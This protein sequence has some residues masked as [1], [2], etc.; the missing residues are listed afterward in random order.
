MLDT[1]GNEIR[2]ARVDSGSTHRTAGE[3]FTL[4]TDDRM[5]NARDVSVS[6][7]GLADE[8]HEGSKILLDDGVIELRV[9]HIEN[10]YRGCFPLLA[11]LDIILS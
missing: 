8:L 11:P 10:P 9:R 6:Y 3:A 7:T 1:K 2:T 5:G 4:Y